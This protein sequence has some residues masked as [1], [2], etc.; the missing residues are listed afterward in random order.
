MNEAETTSWFISAPAVNSFASC[1]TGGENTG[2]KY[3]AFVSFIALLIA[4]H[5][6]L[7][8]LGTEHNFGKWEKEVAAYERMDRTNP[9]PK[10]GVLFIGSS[11]IRLWKSLAQDFPNHRVINRG[12]GG[13]EIVDSTHFADRLIFPHRPKMIF[14]RAGGNDL[15]AGKSPEQ[16]FGDFKDFVAAIH[17]TLPETE[18][19]FI[20]LSP[21]IARWKQAEA[22][23]NVNR[24]VQEHAK[25]NSRLRFI[26]TD[27]MVLGAD[28]K[29][30]AELF[31]ADKLHFSDE[32]YKLL[33][34][35]VGPY[36]PR[37]GAR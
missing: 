3:P 5:A 37:D 7:N 19:A 33:K 36:L 17:A 24:L 25:Q 29:P 15:W 28:G 11:T 34:E 10:D 12:F 6:P 18:I 22:E 13:S 27:D 31:V 26:D 1:S 14:L 21:S 35:R 8:G 4:A 20:S 2:M 16:V 32:G 30:R 9:P 23:R